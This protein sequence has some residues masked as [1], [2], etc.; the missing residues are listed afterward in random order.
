MWGLRPENFNISKACS[1]Q[2]M[3]W[4]FADMPYFNRWMG[5]HTA[6]TCHWRLIPNGLHETRANDYPEDRVKSLGLSLRD[7]RKSG[8]HIL[9]APSSDTMTNWVTGR[10]AKQWLNE[11]LAELKKHTDRPIVIRNKPRKNVTSGPMVETKSVT[12]DLKDCWAVVT[13]ASI[14][15]VEAAIAGIPVI[16]HPSSATSTIS[17]DQLSSIEKPRMPERQSWINTL[18]YRQFTKAEMRSGLAYEVLHQ[19]L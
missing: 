3:P 2:K 11:T 6:E 5:E 14:V 17:T 8:S 4:L 10:Y 12:E 1:N 7:W 16:S 19:L 13:L 18:S 15:G 9:I